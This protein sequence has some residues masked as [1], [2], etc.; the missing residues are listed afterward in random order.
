[1]KYLKQF[2]LYTLVG[3]FNTGINFFLMP[4]LSHFIKPDAY[5]ILSMVN[6]FVSIL[7]PL[8]GLV[9]SGLIFV[10][11]YKGHNKSEFASIFSSIQV[12]PFALTIILLIPALL[13]Q[14]SIA[15]F[16]EIPK[17]KSYWIPIS[18]IIAFLSVYNDTLLSL[19][20]TEQKPVSYTTFAI[21]KVI[22]EV[23]LTVL[24]VTVFKWDWEGRL[25]SWLTSNLVFFFISLWYFRRAELFTRRITWNYMR[26]GILFGL[27]LILH[28]IGK[29]VVNQSDRVFIAKMVSLDEAGIYNI[30]YQV[31]LVIL[32]VINA[33]GNFYNP[34][35][36]E[37]LERFDADAKRQIVIT[38]Y[39]LIM[40]FAVSLI[41]IVLI[42]PVLFSFLIDK[43]Y[44]EGQKYVFWVGLSYFFWGIYIIYS[45]FIFYSKKTG[46]LG[47]LAIL[48]V[49]LN[50]I[51]NFLLIKQFGA[52]GAA[53]AT[54]ISFFV[55]AAIVVFYATRLYN[56]PWFN[57]RYA[58]KVGLQKKILDR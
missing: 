29:F 7:I 40:L 57:F 34:F 41:F 26:A 32:L 3:V 49:L 16:L 17:M 46:F 30:G 42:A 50:V 44:S 47:W 55:I 37:R 56:L 9:A 38:S 10:E 1:M 27:P 51:L 5:G 28:T 24:F 6:S 33:A 54:C 14:T 22:V 39:L 13:F 35:L 15:G 31:G 2:S 12:I 52:L 18:I 45:G 11:Y 53:Y 21:S 43:A 19:N 58:Q 48:N 20:V 23:A 25:L 8:I 4:Y 36:Y